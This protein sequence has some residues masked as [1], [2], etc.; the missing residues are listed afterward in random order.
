MM[1]KRKKIYYPDSQIEKNLFTEGKEWMYLKDWKE[2]RGFYHKYTNGEVFTEREWD[3][4]R[5]E[6]L[7]PYKQKSDSYFRY[8]DIKQYSLF[9]GQKYQNIGPQKFYTYTAPRAVKRLPTD[10]ETQN[11]FMERVFVYKRNERNRVMFEVDAK[12][13]ENFEKDNTG[14]N[15]YLYGYVKIPWK[16]DG[17]ERDIFDGSTLKTP[18]VIDTNQRIIDRFSKKFPILRSILTNPREHS[19]Y[20]R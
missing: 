3:P 9:Q 8:L 2:Y 17:P 10:I 16:L 1:V 15:Q 6:V 5:S 20:D 18:G 14:I 4:N 7:V 11:G 13:I 19:K 12:Q